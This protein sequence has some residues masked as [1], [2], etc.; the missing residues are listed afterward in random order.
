MAISKNM[1]IEIKYE[2]VDFLNID[3][4]YNHDINT[5][6][7]S[8]LNIPKA[9][10]RV[11]EVSGGKSKINFSV[12]IYDNHTELNLIKIERYSFIPNVTCDASNFIQQSYEYLK[13]LSCYQ[14]AVDVLEEGQTL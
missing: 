6:I 1:D 13:T 8:V 11:E 7:V 4:L 3:W 10:I 14:D 9:Y 2:I 5:Q 12:G